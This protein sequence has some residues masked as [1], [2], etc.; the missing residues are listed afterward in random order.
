MAAGSILLLVPQPVC[1]PGCSLAAWRAAKH[2]PAIGGDLPAPLSCFS[3]QLISSTFF[4]SSLI[5][6]A[7]SVLR[8]LQQLLFFL[9]FGCQQA[10]LGQFF[11]SMAKRFGQ[12][13][14]GMMFFCFNILQ[15]NPSKKKNSAREDLSPRALPIYIYKVIS[16][17]CVLYAVVQFSL[18]RV[19]PAVHRP[20]KIAC[21]AADPLKL[22]AFPG[23]LRIAD[24]VVFHIPSSS[25]P[26]Y[27]V[28]LFQ[29]KIKMDPSFYRP[30]T[31]RKIFSKTTETL[32]AS[33]FSV[34]QNVSSGFVVI[35]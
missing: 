34:V 9:L 5:R 7:H 22:H 16:L 4:R 20:H 21:D 26:L 19:I 25:R 11:R 30:A 17:L 1:A 27:I 31:E 24:V 2:V 35:S 10:F 13:C 29:R 6:T 18:L 8:R 33:T 14:P 32:P 23:A 28:P 15:Q 12:F 3:Q